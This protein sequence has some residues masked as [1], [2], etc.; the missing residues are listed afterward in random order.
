MIK[1]EK[2]KKKT[3]NILQI[4]CLNLVKGIYQKKKK[5]LFNTVMEGL[6]IPIRGGKVFK[7]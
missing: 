4:D 6:T 1:G 7:M 2:K 5:M 3:L